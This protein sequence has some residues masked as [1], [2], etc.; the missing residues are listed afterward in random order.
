MSGPVA[1]LRSRARHVVRRIIAYEHRL[2]ARVFSFVA[3]RQEHPAPAPGQPELARAPRE[4]E[5]RGLAALAPYLQLAP[6]HAEPEPGAERL[7]AGLLGGEAC[8]E[9]RHGV[10]PRAAVR[11]LLL[12]EDAPQE[13]VLPA[14]D[15]VAPARDV[16]AVHAD[17]V[18]AHP[19]SRTDLGP[20]EPGELVRHGAH[21]RA[22]GALDHHARQ[23]LRARVT[24][25]DAARAVHLALERGH[26][27]GEPRDR[28]DGRLR[29]DRNVAED[30]RELGEAP[31]ERGERLARL[32]GDAEQGER[33]ENAVPRGRVVAEQDVPRL[34]TAEVHA[35]AL[36]LLV[37]VTV[38]HLGFD[39][40]DARRL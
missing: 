32:G 29:L 24:N 21:A 17:A 6:A 4:H 19:R 12:G 26:A 2:G 31:G 7:E 11:D 15:H 8:G 27:L 33:R 5:R 13:A 3:E 28:L 30:L 10:A 23:G 39:D 22:V 25:E 20:D 9:V 34:L 1:T 35:Q 37:H 40:A 36:H 16:D 18:D 38:A 14:V